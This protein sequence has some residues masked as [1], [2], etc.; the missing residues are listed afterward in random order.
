MTALLLLYVGSGLLLMLV[1]L[2]L[3]C[4]KVPPNRFYG[5]R[6][7]A[8]LQD[9]AVWYAVNRFAARRLIWSG[10]ALVLAAMLFFLIPGLSR[11]VYGW[12]CLGVTIIALGITIG[13]SIRRLNSLTRSARPSTPG[14]VKPQ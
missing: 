11:D 10:A 7:R 12:V 8:T 13:Q 5:F 3:L 4:E 1:G 14:K 9:R 6:V 2:P